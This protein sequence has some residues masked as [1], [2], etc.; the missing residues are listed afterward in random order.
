MEH[1][2]ISLGVLAFLVFLA[3]AF[4]FMNGFH[5]AANAIATVV[6]TRVLKPHTAVML[7]AVCNVVAIFIFELKVAATVGK[8]TI[9][10]F[11]IDY[12]VVFG[13]LV[14]AIAWNVITWY[15][16]IPSSSS[17][18]LIG[19]LIGAALAKTGPSALIS[20]GIIKTV[21]FILISPLLGRVLG[22]LMMI[23]VSWAFRKSTPRRVDI[24]SRRLQLISAS[25]YALGHG[26]NDAQKT[27][28]I[29][30]MLLIAAGVTE[31]HA[32]MPPLWVVI[33]CYAAIGIGTVFGGWR[34]IKLMGQKITKLK[35]VGGFCA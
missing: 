19:G 20:G 16:G 8:G 3:L 7:A 35:P 15:Y 10:L 2:N 30:W 25:A 29:I 12:H 9:E 26:G 23:L 5:D 27:I 17:H 33:S 24:W 11:A 13:A 14:G 31:A 18:A 32:A 6:S 34:I 28:G 21:S 1:L 4:D 22:S